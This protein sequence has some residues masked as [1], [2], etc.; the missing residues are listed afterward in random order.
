[1]N[2]KTLLNPNRRRQ[3]T[4]VADHR[5][6]LIATLTGRYLDPRKAIAGQGTGFSA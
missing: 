1:M 5:H 6:S 4:I 3:T 2:W